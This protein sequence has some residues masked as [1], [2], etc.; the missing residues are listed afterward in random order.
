L[1]DVGRGLVSSLIRQA[2]LRFNA[3]QHV[4]AETILL[5]AIEKYPNAPDL[6]G[7]LGFMYRRVGRVADARAQFEAAYKLKSKNQETYIHWQKM[8]IAGKEWSKALVVADRAL[9]ILPDA[10]EI[11]ERKV[12]TLRQ[13]GFD[14]YRGLHYEKATKMWTDAVDEVE[15]HI[16]NPETLPTGARYLNASMYYSVVVCLDMLRRVKDRNHWLERWEKEHPDDPQVTV[17][18][19]IIRR[20]WG[21]L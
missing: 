5:G 16:K 21:T 17:E 14:M 1:P 10:Y 20:K 12:Y 7:I 6:Q 13:A 15:R 2:L 3:E 4:E 19:D 8:E 11:I 18:K 9:K